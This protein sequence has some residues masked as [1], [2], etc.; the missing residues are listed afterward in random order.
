MLDVDETEHCNGD[1]LE[2]RE[3]NSNGKLIGIYCGQNAPSILPTANTYWIKFRSDDDGVGK[4][5]L[6]E[7][8]Y[9][10]VSKH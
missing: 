10:T 9:G 8:N 3:N 2:I 5:F 7:Y 6:I 4:G 1:Y